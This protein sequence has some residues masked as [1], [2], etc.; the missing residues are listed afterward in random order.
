LVLIGTV[1]FLA[2]SCGGGRDEGPR[3][4]EGDAA[5]SFTL[6]SAAGMDVSLSDFARERPVLL[7]FS[8]GPG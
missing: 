3:L 2:V 4:A 8:M 6:S 7:Y 1:V 5:P